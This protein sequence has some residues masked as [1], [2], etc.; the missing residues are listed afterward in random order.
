MRLVDAH[1]NIEIV[2]RGECLRLLG[3]EEVG[4]VAFATGAG[5]ADIL[6]IN[7]VVDGD[8]V[9]FATAAGSKLTSAE[10]GSLTFEADHTDASTRSGWSVVIHGFAQVITNFDRPELVERLRAL[11]INPWA[12]GDRPHLVRIAPGTITGRR[13]GPHPD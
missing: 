2:D 9:V 6:P 4:R 7:Y 12:G 8:A 11:P 3:T 10:R 1:S 5:A 13:V